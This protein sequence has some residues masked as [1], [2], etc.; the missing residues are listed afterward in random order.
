MTYMPLTETGLRSSGKI[1]L[2]KSVLLEYWVLRERSILLKPVLGGVRIVASSISS[3]EQ[4]QKKK[5][6]QL[7]SYIVDSLLFSERPVFP[8][9]IRL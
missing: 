8:D 6:N 3:H 4:T 9:Y 1:G 7:F 2:F 5:L